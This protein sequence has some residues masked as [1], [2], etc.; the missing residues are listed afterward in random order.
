MQLNDHFEIFEV[1]IEITVGDRVSHRRMEAPRVM[2]E[3]Q[4]LGLM[5][6]AA[7]HPEPVRIHMTRRVPLFNPLEQKW[8]DHEHSITY[9]NNAYISHNGEI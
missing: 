8:E 6:D 7:N 5:Q 4:F 1:N 2:I 3:Q 9:A